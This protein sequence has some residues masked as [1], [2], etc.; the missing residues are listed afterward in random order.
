VR[1]TRDA[2]ENQSGFLDFRRDGCWSINPEITPPSKREHPMP[3]NLKDKLHMMR[4]PNE[5]YERLV[6]MADASEM[7]PSVMLVQI[8]RKTFPTQDRQDTS[9]SH[10]K[11]IP[12]S[13]GINSASP[14]LQ[15]SA[16]IGA[17]NS[18]PFAPKDNEH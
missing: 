1:D 11:N 9:P 4:I 7:P 3:R 6:A 12:A 18:N 13:S 14:S 2:N 15:E 8:L 17:F 10:F 5:I 16:P